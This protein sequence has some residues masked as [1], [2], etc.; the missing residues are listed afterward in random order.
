MNK[1]LFIKVLYVLVWSAGLLFATFPL[2][3]MGGM[4]FSFQENLTNKVLLGY[5]F[6]FI[7]SMLI[8]LIDII[9]TTICEGRKGG[10][11]DVPLSWMLLGGYLLCFVFS[12][13]M[14]KWI[15][16]IIGWLCLTGLKLIKTESL[17]CVAYQKVSVV[18][19]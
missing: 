14:G 4:D 15:F 1:D 5:I 17:P 11:K 16:F 10:Y 3:Y 19:E 13:F 6:P 9:Y 7:T 8:F 12:L 18:E 2:F